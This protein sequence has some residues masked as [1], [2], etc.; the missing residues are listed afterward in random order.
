MSW[1]SDAVDKVS[2]TL[3]EADP[4]NPN[5]AVSEALKKIDPTLLAGDAA[6]MLEPMAMPLAQQW[7]SEH[8]AAQSSSQSD[9]DDCVTV[10]ASGL[11]AAGAAL[12]SSAV[13]VGAIVGAAIG[14][15]AGIP[16]ARLACRRI[17][18]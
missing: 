7:K 3:S 5:S 14:A 8:P 17:F 9:I 18:E 6:A 11:T 1:F 4:T 2:D 16:A 10:V 13:G 12:G 15:G